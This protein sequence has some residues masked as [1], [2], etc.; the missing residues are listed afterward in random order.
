MNTWN[1]RAKARLKEIGRTQDWLAEQFDMTTGGMQKWLAG[2]RQPSL[3][4]I[5]RIARL[6]NCPSV[7]LTHGLDPADCTDGLAEGARSTLRRLI[8]A[9]R[10]NPLPASFWQAV[11]AMARTVSPT[12]ADS[13]EGSSESPTDHAAPRNGTHG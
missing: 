12:L 4:E 8:V 2:T 13:T 9:E 3:E 11:N 1:S 5:N 7:W 6:L 10:S